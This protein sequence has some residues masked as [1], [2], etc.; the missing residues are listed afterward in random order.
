[1]GPEVTGSLASVSASIWPRS[2]RCA[3]SAHDHPLP[4]SSRRIPWDGAEHSH[5]GRSS[6]PLVH[7][8]TTERSRVSKR[9]P[10]DRSK[11]PNSNSPRL[12]QAPAIPLPAEQHEIASNGD[13]IA[14]SNAERVNSNAMCKR[15]LARS[16]KLGFLPAPLPRGQPRLNEKIARSN[17]RN[18]GAFLRVSLWSLDIFRRVRVCLRGW[19]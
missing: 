1:M 15:S 17:F 8:E 19:D 18:C 9:A 14:H 2:S 13:L 10:K 3:H 12:P 4:H 11:D 7:P 6:P 5:L 16:E